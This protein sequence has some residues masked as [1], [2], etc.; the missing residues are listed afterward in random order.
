MNL[1]FLESAIKSLQNLEERQNLIKKG[2]QYAKKYSWNHS[3][4]ETQSVYETF[5]KEQQHTKY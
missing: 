2:L 5:F 4:I 3:V 1:E